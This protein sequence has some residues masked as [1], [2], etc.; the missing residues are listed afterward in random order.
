MYTHMYL[1]IHMYTYMYF[2]IYIYIYTSYRSII[3]DIVKPIAALLADAEQ[4]YTYA[5]LDGF[6]CFT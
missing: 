5:L 4:V 6:M 1:R 2:Y 3:T